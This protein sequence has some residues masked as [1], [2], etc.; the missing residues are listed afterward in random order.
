[1]E[2]SE[3]VPWGRSFAEYLRM[4]GLSDADLA[5]RRVLG[6]GDGPASFNAEATALGHRVVSCDPIYAFPAGEIRQRVAACYEAVV[7]QARRNAHRFVWDEFRDADELGQA[8]LAVM[9][10]FLA[11]YETGRGS[12]RYVPASLPH[13]PFAAGTFDLCVCSHL[14]FLYSRQ[15]DLDFHLSAVREMLRVAAEVRVFPLLDLD[16][17]PS[18]HVGPVQAA[19]RREDGDGRVTIREVSYEFQ[20]GGNRMLV[21]TG[22]G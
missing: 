4:F 20:R 21:I 22:R 16:G 9:E 13:L 17:E 2:L 14:L 6:C 19:L 5:G 8:R 11:D 1:M 15:L 12:G 7:E 18:P 3:V 10:R